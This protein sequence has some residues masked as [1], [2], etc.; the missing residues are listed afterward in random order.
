MKLRFLLRVLFLSLFWTISSVLASD[1][2]P[3]GQRL[4]LFVD[5]FMIQHMSGTA[6]QILHKPEP[7]E[8]VFEAN[9]SW[10]GNTCFPNSMFWDNDRFVLYYRCSHTSPPTPDHPSGQDFLRGLAR[11]ESK[12]GIVWE[13]PGM[14][15]VDFNGLRRNNMLL[16]PPGISAWY[17]GALPV[18]KNDN[19]NA[20]SDYRYF[21]TVQ[22]GDELHFLASSNGLDWKQPA[23]S[24]IIST[25]NAF[26]SINTLF[27]DTHSHLYRCYYRLNRWPPGRKV[28]LTASTDL[29]HWTPSVELQYTGAKDEELYTNSIQNYPR[30][31]HILVGF[32]TIIF[33]QKGQVAPEFMSSR[34]GVTFRRWEE[35]IIPITAPKD[36]DGNRSNFMTWGFLA[37]PSD[38]KNYSFYATEAYYAGPAS[39]LR[40]FTYRIDGFV[41]VSVHA[42]PGELL[43][44]PL[45]FAGDTLV[46][47]AATRS[48]GTV[49]VEVLDAQGQTI[50]GLSVA[51]C[52]AFTG[53][54]IEHRVEWHDASQL[55]QSAGKPIQLRFFLQEAELY[56][57]RFCSTNP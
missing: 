15:R 17:G 30:A 26:D 25:N 42:E 53:D 57:F 41:S 40:R 5:D 16:L 2:I 44:K 31:P 8:V 46:I 27:W 24:L 51:N 11:A 47:N 34:D 39:R 19:P 52:R 29:K 9:R 35:R 28:M 22:I 32:P 7:R 6:T 4:E 12:D 10:E 50:R 13:R 3:L 36:R 1:A 14:G 37:L 33:G 38:P 55:K 21:G 49:R 43:T 23:N 20:T 18:M 56:S 45:T 54:E 48:N